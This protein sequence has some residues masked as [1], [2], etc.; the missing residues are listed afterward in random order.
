MEGCNAAVDRRGVKPGA[1][2]LPRAAAMEARRVSARA[3]TPDAGAGDRRCRPAPRGSDDDAG[4]A[5]SRPRLGCGARLNSSAWAGG[6]EARTVATARR[7]RLLGGATG[8]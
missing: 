5:R 2:P 4:G 8:E 6:G 3:G 1:G 7:T